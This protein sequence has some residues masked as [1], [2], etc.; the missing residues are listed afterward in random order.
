MRKHAYL[1]SLE[2]AVQDGDLFRTII[3]NA[4]DMISVHNLDPGGTYRYV[5]PTYVQ[6]SEYEY[7]ELIGLTPYLVFEKVCFHS[8]HVF[9]HE[10]V[11]CF[12]VQV[13]LII[14]HDMS[15]HGMFVMTLG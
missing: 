7:D 5:S 14:P 15:Q 6:K 3:Q 12:S 8:R 11:P 13:A 1:T 9:G 2:L 10:E 4:T